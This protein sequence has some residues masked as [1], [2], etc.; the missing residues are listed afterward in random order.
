MNSTPLPATPL[1][2]PPEP[3]D[4]VASTSYS[5]T[6]MYYL[7]VQH[8]EHKMF[9]HGRGLRLWNFRDMELCDFGI[10]SPYIHS[11]KLVDGESAQQSP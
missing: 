6:K 3:G 2:R 5:G 8:V 7:V 10:G 9:N 1:P 4:I 11:M